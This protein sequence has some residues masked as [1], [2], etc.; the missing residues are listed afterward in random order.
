MPFLKIYTFL[1]AS[2]MINIIMSI[3]CEGEFNLSSGLILKVHGNNSK[4]Y[5]RAFFIF[6]FSVHTL[7]GTKVIRFFKISDNITKTNNIYL[8]YIRTIKQ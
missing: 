7:I 4:V 5:I 8:K 2:T 3:C 1:I 6:K